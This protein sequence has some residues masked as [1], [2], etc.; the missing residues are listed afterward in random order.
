MTNT[1][2]VI[3]ISSTA[4]KALDLL[5]DRGARLTWMPCALAQLQPGRGP[6]IVDLS[7][8]THTQKKNIP[9]LIE[10][11][12]LRPTKHSANKFYI[13]RAM[14]FVSVEPDIDAITP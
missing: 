5:K 3:N 11:G 8:L 1:T 10:L 14:A 6:Q 7:D 2:T 13:P 12:L 9:E 4:F